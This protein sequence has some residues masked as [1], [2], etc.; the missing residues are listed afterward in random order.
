M[1][2]GY[3]MFRDGEQIAVRHG[4]PDAASAKLAATKEAQATVVS[5]TRDLTFRVCYKYA[6][7]PFRVEHDGTAT[8]LLSL[9]ATDKVK[10][11]PRP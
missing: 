6:F 7:H 10:A 8:S 1:N 11:W 4:F 9:W 2:F 5:H 3:Q